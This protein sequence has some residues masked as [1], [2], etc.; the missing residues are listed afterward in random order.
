MDIIHFKFFLSKFTVR[1]H[2]V[3]L[4]VSKFGPHLQEKGIVRLNVVTRIVCYFFVRTKKGYMPR[5]RNM[6]LI[7]K[8]DGWR[9]NHGLISGDTSCI[10]FISLKKCVAELCSHFQNDSVELFFFILLTWQY[11]TERVGLDLYSGG[12]LFEFRPRHQLFCPRFILVFSV[13]PSKYLN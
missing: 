8:P 4:N 9:S 6:T 2:V 12:G 10:I 3:N 5:K 11:I 1:G 7:V 13:P